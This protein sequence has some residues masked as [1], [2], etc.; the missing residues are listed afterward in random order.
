MREG[1]GGEV[2]ENQGAQN[3]VVISYFGSHILSIG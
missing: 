1:G 2:S 3:F